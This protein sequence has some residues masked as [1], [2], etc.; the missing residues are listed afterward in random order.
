[1]SHN[2]QLESYT[3]RELLGLFDLNPN[4]IKVED[5]KKAKKK[6]LMMHPDKSKLDPSYFLFYKKAFDVI[7][8]MYEN[9]LKMSQIVEDKEYTPEKSAVSNKELKKN[10]QN[11]D[12]G[13]FHQQFNE[14]FL[15]HGSKIIDPSK[16]DWFTSADS[17]YHSSS[18]GSVSQIHGSIDRIKEKQQ[19]LI[20]YKGVNPLMS[21]GGNG[22]YDDDDQEYVECDPFSK[23][24][25]DDLR[26]VHKDQTVFAVRESDM[27]NVAQY[28]NVEELKNARRNVRPMERMHAEEMLKEQDRIVRDKMTQ[29]QYQS[30]LVTIRN[31]ETNKIVMANFLKLEGGAAPL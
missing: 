9:V 15:K 25:Y 8:V 10:L 1:M 12:K 5:L 23:L 29:K 26:K 2:L 13:D 7:V 11:I 20:T 28:K 6:V 24:K 16:N 4:E 14:L 27:A 21:F 30:E 22:L 17:L 18:P 31:I 3:L 19:Q